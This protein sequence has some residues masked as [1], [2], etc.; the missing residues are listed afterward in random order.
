MSNNTND[1]IRIVEP[2]KEE[3]EQRIFSFEVNIDSLHVRGSRP[4]FEVCLASVGTKPED[5]YK[6]ATISKALML[7]MEHLESSDDFYGELRQC[8]E[9]AESLV[10]KFKSFSEQPEVVKLL[11]FWAEVIESLGQY[12]TT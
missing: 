9:F 1:T 4:W 3:I 11:D 10:A 7:R 8:L 12:L 6:L 2:T 5:L